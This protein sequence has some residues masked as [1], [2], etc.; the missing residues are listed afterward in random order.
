MELDEVKIAEA[1]KEAEEIILQQL[2]EVKEHTF[3]PAFKK[4]MKQL[5]KQEKY[6]RTNELKRRIAIA[7]IVISIAGGITVSVEAVR[8]RVIE[9]ITEVFEKFT[10]ITY[11]KNEEMMGQDLHKYYLPQYIPQGFVLAGQEQIFNDVYYT[12]Q[13]ELGEEILLYQLEID[14]NNMIIDTEDTVVEEFVLQGKHIY[15]YENKGIKNVMWIQGSYQFVISSEIEKN[16][17]IKMRLSVE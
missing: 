17:L 11:E 8:I 9:F 2:N 12:Y 6:N 4:K 15:Y 13:N 16:E 10:S 3:S 5:F 1:A 14:T 7:F